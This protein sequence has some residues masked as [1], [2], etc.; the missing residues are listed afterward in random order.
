MP[1]VPPFLEF[2]AQADRKQ[3]QD[4]GR[5]PG[6]RLQQLN[7]V[8]R[9]AAGGQIG[10][11]TPT[12]P[13]P[14]RFL[15]APHQTTTGPGQLLPIKQTATGTNHPEAVLPPGLVWTLP[16]LSTVVTS[17][18]EEAVEHA[19]VIG[20]PDRAGARLACCQQKATPRGGEGS[21]A[22][23]AQLPKQWLTGDAETQ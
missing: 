1:A 19:A 3:R 21:T 8:G 14:A 10:N 6:A 4:C 2:S 20:T 7:G 11:E 5:G 12:N 13:S 15:A 16:W 23:T 9:T 17:A 18:A 22:V